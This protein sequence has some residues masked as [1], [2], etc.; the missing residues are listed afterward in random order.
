MRDPETTVNQRFSELGATPTPWSDTL[1]TIESAELFWIATVRADG[2][3][4][5]TPLVGVWADD[6]LYFSTGPDEPKAV[7]RR[8]NDH[9]VLTTGSSDWKGGRD[10][11]VEGVAHRVQ[12][13]D[14]LIRVAEIWT[15]KW[16]RH[17]TYAVGP[18]CIHHRDGDQVLDGEV[19]VFRVAPKKVLAFARGTFS[20]TRY[21]FN[22]SS[23]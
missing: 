16:D 22:A 17:W 19:Y 4:H 7:N 12:S 10:V 23:A 6:A 1:A 2:R 21:Q 20:H 3:P 11:V 15:H 5:V 14:E 9:V 8:H 18:G 13:D